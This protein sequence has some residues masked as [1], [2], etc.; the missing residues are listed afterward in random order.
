MARA[1]TTQDNLYVAS[2]TGTVTA[3]GG[4]YCRVPGTVVP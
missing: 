4:H 1:H 3:T 2:T